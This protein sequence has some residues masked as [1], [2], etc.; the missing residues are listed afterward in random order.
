[1]TRK[2]PRDQRS[3]AI[4]DAAVLEFAEKGFENASMTSIAKRARISKGGVY[5]HFPSKD[6]ILAAANE[7]I[8]EPAR[9]AL[10]AAAHVESPAERL[11]TYIQGYLEH[12]A[13]N[14]KELGFIFTS[15]AKSIHDPA[16]FAPYD[17]YIAET[18]AG[19]AAVYQEGVDQGEFRDLDCEAQA[20][21]LAAA[22]DGVTLYLNAHADEPSPAARMAGQLTA[23]LVDSLRP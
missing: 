3:A 14:R 4:I 19:L 10:N 9:L 8:S 23:A 17:A 5:H 13:A 16:L 1:M 7:R 6:A 22:L 18:V 2:M 20:L 15:I 11:T 12:W 21:A